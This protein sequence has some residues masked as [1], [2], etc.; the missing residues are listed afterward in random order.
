MRYLKDIEKHFKHISEG[1]NL[2]IKQSDGTIDSGSEIW[3]DEQF[4]RKDYTFN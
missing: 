3:R 2:C 1:L 4:K